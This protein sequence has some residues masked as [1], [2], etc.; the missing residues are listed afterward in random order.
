MRTTARPSGV[1]CLFFPGPSA[2]REGV[3][4]TP[5]AASPRKAGP[6]PSLALVTLTL[7]KSTG[8]VPSTPLRVESRCCS[9]RGS[10]GVTGLGEESRGDVPLP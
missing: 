8:Q 3:G 1:A 7:L 4:A 2:L 5:K 9:P 6:L 10:T